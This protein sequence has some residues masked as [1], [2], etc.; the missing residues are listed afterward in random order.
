[1]STEALIGVL[2][3][4]GTLLLV[5]EMHGTEQGPAQQDQWPVQQDRRGERGPAPGPYDPVD[6]VRPS[7][8]APRP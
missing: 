4:A 2:S 8:F 5:G 6:A 1:M 3:I 7:D